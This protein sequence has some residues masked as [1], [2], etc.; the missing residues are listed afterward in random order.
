MPVRLFLRLTAVTTAAIGVVLI[1]VPG[2]IADV[3]L[4]QR[5]AGSN[6][7][8]QFLGSSLV[9]YTLINWYSSHVDDKALLH[10]TITG[11]LGTLTIAAVLSV[12]GL[13][14]HALRPSGVLIL[15]LHVGFGCGFAYFWHHSPKPKY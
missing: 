9:G 12:V 6:I 2:I 7:F 8:I 5:A 14:N 4:T 15:L 10:A 11:N 1:L 3:F 13:A